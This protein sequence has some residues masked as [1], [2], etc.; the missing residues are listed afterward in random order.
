MILFTGDFNLRKKVVSILE[1][2]LF[3]VCLI[4]ILFRINKILEPKYAYSNSK[5]TT[6][7]NYHEFY[8][9]KRNSVDVLFL[10]SSI[11][12]NAFSPQEIYNETGIRSFN[13]ASE[14]QATILSAYWL[15]EALRFQSPKVVV[16]DTRYFFGEIPGN[17]LMMEEGLMRKCMDPM[18]WSDIKCKAVYEI[19]KADKNQSMAS[20]VFTNLRF[21]ERWKELSRIDFDEKMLHGELKGYSFLTDRPLYSG[22]LLWKQ[23]ESYAKEETA[24]VQ[25]L[26][27]KGM[28]K[29]LQLCSENGIQLLLISL[30]GN[31][32]N[33]G[34]CSVLSSYAELENVD[35]LN[36]NTL[37]FYESL[38]IN[39]EIENVIYHANLWGSIRLSQYIGKYLKS[40]YNLPAVFDEQYEQTRPDYEHVKISCELPYIDELDAYL[41]A[42]L[43]DER[44]SILLSVRMDASASLTEKQEKLFESLGMDNSL[45]VFGQSVAALLSHNQIEIETGE[46][47][48]TLTGS[49]HKKREVFEITSSGINQYLESR[50]KIN[51]EE[52]VWDR[53]GINMVVYDDFLEKIVD[54]VNFNTH[55]G[56]K[57][58]R[59]Q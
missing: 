20:Y 9:M 38:D 36:M 35:F 25:P 34:I 29:I 39:P 55:S 47:P 52:L 6:T 15:E 10:G 31:E 54:V 8:K 13:L 46:L 51:K 43:A 21:H 16:F 50:I 40:H 7:S 22:Q 17:P 4:T 42:L 59:V 28:D 24:L 53:P 5:W 1:I 19:C 14:Q 48:V 2:V 3:S 26:M 57:A 49:F 33:D 58:F 18:K 12:M 30:P 23:T 27:Q 45:S 44:F 32:M 11:M 37:D 41:E 56:E